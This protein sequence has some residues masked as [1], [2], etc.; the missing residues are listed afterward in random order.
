MPLEWALIF[1]GTI[2]ACVYFSYNSGLRTGIEDATVLTL[3]KLEG[4]GLI[5]FDNRGNIKSGRNKEQCNERNGAE[6]I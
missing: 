5:H 4:D 1:M 3:A 6:D 2:V